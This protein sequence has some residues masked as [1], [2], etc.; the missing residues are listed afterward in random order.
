MTKVNN[1]LVALFAV[2]LGISVHAK[3]MESSVATVNGKPVLA[4]EY[5]SYLQSVVE[6]YEVSAPQVLERPYAKDILGSKI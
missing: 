5:D 6:Q 4:S 1:I 2:A 3:V